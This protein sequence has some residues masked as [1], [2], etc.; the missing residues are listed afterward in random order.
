MELWFT[1]S[2]LCDLY[3]TLV[4]IY[5]NTEYPITVGYSKSI[6]SV[7]IERPQT[8]I[9]GKIPFPH[10]LHKATVLMDTIVNFHP[11][12]D[13]NKRT[14]LLATFYFLYWNGYDFH[15]PENADDFLIDIVL[16]KFS[17]NEICMWLE[18]NCRRNIT[19]IFRNLFCWSC[20]MLGNRP[21]MQWIMELFYPLI[22]PIYPFAYLRYVLIKKRKK[23]KQAT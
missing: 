8:G 6:I 22:F 19:S 13:G 17:L 4:N 16:G 14:G 7:C 5:K 10:L 21:H 18:N 12:A 11:F 9:Y 15:I 23:V 1:E 2:W 20:A 3:E